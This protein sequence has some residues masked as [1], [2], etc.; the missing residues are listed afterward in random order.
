M[1]FAESEEKIM[2][3]ISQIKEELAKIK[4]DKRLGYPP[5]TVDIIAPLAL[6]QLGL[7]SRIDALR[8]VLSKEDGKKG[9]KK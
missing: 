6:I 9:K 3:S 4:A 7:E 2:K 1:N 5:A 8:W